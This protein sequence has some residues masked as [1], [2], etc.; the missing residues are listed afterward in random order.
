[1]PQTR[2]GLEAFNAPSM[3][4][5]NGH[6]QSQHKVCNKLNFSHTQHTHTHTRTQRTN[7]T[8]NKFLCRAFILKNATILC[9]TKSLAMWGAGEAWHVKLPPS[10]KLFSSKYCCGFCGFAAA[11]KRLRTLHHVAS[12]LWN[13][14]NHMKYICRK[15]HLNLRLIYSAKWIIMKSYKS[16]NEKSKS[17][18]NMNHI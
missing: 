15:V 16:L 7:R 4:I 11:A 9:S 6:S 13:W 3:Y 12:N 5:M 17:E 8:L 18:W 1:M 14:Q 10:L 2:R